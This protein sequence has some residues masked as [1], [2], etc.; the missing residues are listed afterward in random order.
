MLGSNTI[1]Q[2]PEPPMPYST[3]AM[4]TVSNHHFEPYAPN[5]N[6][7]SIGEMHDRR[8]R[9]MRGKGNNGNVSASS[10]SNEPIGHFSSM[11]SDSEPTSYPSRRPSMYDQ[12]HRS[13]T[14][15]PALGSGHVTAGTDLSRYGQATFESSSRA[16]SSM[17]A[18]VDYS[19]QPVNGPQQPGFGVLG[20][21]NDPRSKRRRGNLPKQVTDILRAWFHDHLDHPYPTEEDKQMFI[22]RTGLSLSQVR[23][24]T[25]APTHPLRMT[26]ETATDQQLVHQREA[27]AIANSAKSSP[28]PR[29]R[30]FFS[31]SRPERTRSLLIS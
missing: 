31:F 7:P 2:Y 20:D 24:S 4:N 8:D 10:F 14:S 22:A 1:P 27:P 30:T 13:H 3:Q 29:A 16:Y 9:M 19:S 6:L 26:D 18:E 23:D 15:Y 5:S 28:I 12:S 11:G 21:S 25:W 17:Y